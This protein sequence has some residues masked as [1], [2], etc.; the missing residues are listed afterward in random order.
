MFNK[1]WN[2]AG[3][4]MEMSRPWGDSMR[5]MEYDDEEFSDLGKS[6]RTDVGRSMRAGNH[7]GRSMSLRLTDEPPLSRELDETEKSWLLEPDTNK[8]QPRRSFWWSLCIIWSSAILI[9]ALSL[10]TWKFAPKK[11]RP[12]PA[13]DNYT[14]ALAKALTFFDIQKCKSS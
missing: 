8:K 3:S 10:V 9:V 6:M 5:S 7:G 4:S 13:P 2:R 1:Q 12:L 11:H 14:V